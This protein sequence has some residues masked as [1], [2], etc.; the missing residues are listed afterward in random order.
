MAAPLFC[1]Q[2][3]MSILAV[4]G[5][6]IATITKPPLDVIVDNDA[7]G[8][9][10]VI[11]DKGSPWL[12]SAAPS[13]LGAALSPC[14]GGTG[15]GAAARSSGED[16]L[17]RFN[18]TQNAWCRPRETEPVMITDVRQ[19]S[20]ADMADTSVTIFEQR[21]PQGTMNSANNCRY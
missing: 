18:S 5:V 21:F 12:R 2:N 17:G 8:S 7:F 19:Y 3:H 13:L 11:D 4:V 14:G 15:G 10:S 1:P 9:F 6:A 20:V 16:K